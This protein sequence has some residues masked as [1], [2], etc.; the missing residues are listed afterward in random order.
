MPDGTT[1]FRARGKDILHYMG[2]S[3]FS[4]YTGI[5]CFFMFDLTLFSRRRHLGC[6]CQSQGSPRQGL[7]PRMWYHHRLRCRHPNRQSRKGLYLR[8]LWSRLRRSQRHSRL[9]R[10]WCRQDH[11]RRHQRRQRTLGQEIRCNRLCQSLPTQQAGSR[12]PHRYHRRWM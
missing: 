11:R 6:R 7:S 12:I 1:R 8:H 5:C 9:R 10:Q 4:Q 2:T 3:T